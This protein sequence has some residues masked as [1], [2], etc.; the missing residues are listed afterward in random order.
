MAALIEI[1][2]LL[3]RAGCVLALTHI[4][5]DGD[6]IGSLLGFG[7]ILRRAWQSEPGRPA[8]RLILACADPLPPQ[9]QWL[10]GADDIVREPP[11]GPWDAVVALD[12]SDALR[13][14]TAFRP[15]DLATAPLVVIDH[16]I[17]NIRFGALNHVDLT[18]AATAQIIVELADALGVAIGPE[19]AVCLLAGLVTDTLGFR[20]TN[21]TVEVMATAMRLMQAGASLSEIVE[22]TLNH[23]PLSLLRLWSLALT[24]LQLE[25]RVAWASISQAMREQVNAPATGDG[26]LVGQLINAP[27]VVIAAVFAE[28]TTGKVEVGLRAKAGYDVSQVALSLGGGGHPQAAGCTIAGPLAA[29][30]ARVLPLLF[31]LTA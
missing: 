31:Q 27:E 24:T 9:I 7:W 28:T 26:G 17:T 22:R 25:Q 30:E 20:T 23:R 3:R 14:G 5:P 12:A 16:H 8:R 11:A 6:A 2:G 13:L 19:A 1:A 4:A 21:V 15:Q 18:A 10:P 29:A